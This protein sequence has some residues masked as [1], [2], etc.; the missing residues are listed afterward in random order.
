[1]NQPFQNQPFQNQPFQNQ[2]FQNQPFQNQPFQRF[3]AQP[4]DPF[5]ENRPYLLQQPDKI[6][7]H[8]EQN[9]INIT[10]KEI[11][12]LLTQ[13]SYY[14]K[15]KEWPLLIINDKSII[16]LNRNLDEMFQIAMRYPF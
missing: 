2:P 11:T 9:K 7:I 12:Q 13:D 1:M 3:Q 6:K 8:K 4:Y 15:L 14:R 10:K 16:R 5:I